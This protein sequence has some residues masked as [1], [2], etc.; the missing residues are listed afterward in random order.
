MP[1]KHAPIE[2]RDFSLGSL[3]SS[4]RPSV[5][6]HNIP[7][8]NTA[9]PAAHA[10]KTG[11]RGRVG[12]ALFRGARDR[13]PAQGGRGARSGPAGFARASGALGADPL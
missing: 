11:R 9:P 5:S 2:R 7:F 10:P 12:R 3:A 1:S 4:N 6:F 8:Q 13:A